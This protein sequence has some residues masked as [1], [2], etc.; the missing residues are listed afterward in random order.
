MDILFSEKDQ[1]QVRI[2]ASTKI[3]KIFRF[4]IAQE[5]GPQHIRPAN[6][7]Q[8]SKGHEEIP[9]EMRYPF[10]AKVGVP[11]RGIIL[12]GCDVYVS[13][14]RVTPMCIFFDQ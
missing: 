12:W 8:I 3:K 11:I 7:Y 2:D 4:W 5:R 6:R 14:I 13:G 1:Q 9:I 10:L